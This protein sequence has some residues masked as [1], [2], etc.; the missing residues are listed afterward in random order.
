MIVAM[1]FLMFASGC[2]K[3]F[4]AVNKDLGVAPGKKPVYGV[5]TAFFRINKAETVGTANFVTEDFV[6]FVNGN[7]G[8]AIPVLRGES[9]MADKLAIA[10]REDVAA[11]RITQES[12]YGDLTKDFD[13]LGIDG[14]IVVGGFANTPSMGQVLIESAGNAAIAAL[15]GSIGIIPTTPVAMID[16]MVL[17]K[18]GRPMYFNSNQFVRILRRDFGVKGDRYGMYDYLYKNI[19]EKINK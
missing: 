3:N 18:T 12:N 16:T 2:S 8:N 11:R 15:V 14:L 9:A 19:D 5:T 17:S 4:V 10:F 6:K 13:K 7:G 1:I